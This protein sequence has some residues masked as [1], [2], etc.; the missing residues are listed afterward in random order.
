VDILQLFWRKQQRG[1]T[2]TDI[3]AMSILGKR[4]VENWFQFAAILQREHII[5]RT[6]EG[7]YVLA[8]NLDQIRFSDFYRSLPWPL[9]TPDDWAPACG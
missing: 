4:E 8:R 6:D 7:S 9:P 3:E 1:G 5:R 2:V